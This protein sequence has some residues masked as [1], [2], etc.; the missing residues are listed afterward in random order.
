[1]NAPAFMAGKK[2][3]GDEREPFAAYLSDEAT[4]AALTQVVEEHGWNTSRIQAGGIANAVRS[5]SVT[6]SPHILIID[7]TQSVDM[8]ADISALAEVC[9]PGTIVIALGETNDVN[10]YRGLL[11][12]G[13]FDYLVKPASAD[14]LRA[15]IQHAEE[16]LHTEPEPE[17]TDGENGRLITFIGLRGGARASTVANNT[18]WTI[19]ED[20]KQSVGFLDLDVNFGTSALCFDLEPGR[21]LADALDNPGRVDSLFIERAMLKQSENLSILGAESPVGDAAMPDPAALVHLIDEMREHFSLVALDVPRHLMAHY[22]FMLTESAEIVL[23]C[24][25]TLASV[26]DAIRVLGY[27]RDVAP[28][29]KVS[30]VAN[31][32]APINEVA[33]KDFEHAVERSID[34]LIPLD[35]RTAMAA[36]KSAKMLAQI[37][38]TA[39]PV[40]ALKQLAQRLTGT[41]PEAGATPFWV[42]LTQ[43]RPK[44]KPTKAKSGQSKTKSK[45][46]K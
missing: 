32:V 18:A 10:L 44:A 30:L 31:K 43:A 7:L 14:L 5:L 9:E 24:D 3:D 17:A 35:A 37:S 21:G 12:A 33:P 41:E 25:L 22:P 26:R 8:Q 20:I 1:M 16:T 28:K 42:K 38:K 6:A 34:L 15:A 23:V 45:A 19:A 4:T 11:G 27:L 2:A 29:V 36:A 40:T 46:R 39:K 13:I